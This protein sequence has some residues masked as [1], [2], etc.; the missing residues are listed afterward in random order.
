MFISFGDLPSS[1][2]SILWTKSLFQLPSR[3]CLETKD[4]T[5]LILMLQTSVWVQFCLKYRMV[6]NVPSLTR[7]ELWINWCVLY[8][9]E[10]ATR[11]GIWPQTV[12]TISVVSK[13]HNSEWP[14]SFTMVAASCGTRWA[15]GP[16][17]AFPQTVQLQYWTLTGTSA[18]RCRQFEPTSCGV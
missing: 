1:R 18:H 16:M 3:L 15:T 7:D 5:N 14:F 12:K 10:S 4:H 9:T 2:L 13:V 8:H 17:V 11:C 6:M